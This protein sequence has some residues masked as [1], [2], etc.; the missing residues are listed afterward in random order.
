MPEFNKSFQHFIVEK[1][2]DLAR[3]KL[4]L[5]Y[6]LIIIVLYDE[7]KFTDNFVFCGVLT[8]SEFECSI[9]K[10]FQKHFFNL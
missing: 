7:S 3:K 9:N 1:N 2:S 6:N 8:Y 5:S 4:I 10:I